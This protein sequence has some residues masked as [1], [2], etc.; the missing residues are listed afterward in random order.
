MR[1]FAQGECRAAE[2]VVRVYYPHVLRT[3]IL[4]CRDKDLAEDLT[5]DTFVKARFRAMAFEGAGT[6]KAWLTKI[7]FRE[8]LQ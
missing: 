5:Q 2:E 7:A 1:R 4:L 8:Y 3:L 6:V